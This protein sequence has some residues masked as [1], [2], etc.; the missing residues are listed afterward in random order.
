MFG[1]P[2][3]PKSKTRIH[4]LP[5][6]LQLATSWG[7]AQGALAATEF[8]DIDSLITESAANAFVKL[9]G[10]GMDHRAYEPATPLGTSLGLDVGLEATLV[11]P[12]SDLGTALSGLGGAM[13]G[14]SSSS[15]LTIPILPSPKLHLHKGLSNRI[16]IG[17]TGLYFPSLIPFVGGSYFVGG[18]VKIILFQP[19]EGLTWAF[20][21]SYNV[22][23]LTMSQSS[24]ALSIKTGTYTP[25]LIVSRKLSFADPYMGMG[26]QISYGTFAATITLPE[27]PAP[28]PSLGDIVLSKNGTASGFLLFGGVGLRIPGVGFKF[29]IEGAYSPIGMNYLG[30]KIS[31]A[32]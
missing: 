21:M 11:Q 9:I 6:L 10:M 19:E 31:F 2:P 29:T 14:G 12:P 5:F 13:G 22:N 17:L 1:N 32:Y 20:R 24:I 26:Y 30:T 3:H 25:Q 8:P 18:D 7:W 23:S 4:W 15:S 27:L 28:S 16:D